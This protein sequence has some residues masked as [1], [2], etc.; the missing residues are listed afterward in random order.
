MYVP[1]WFIVALG[2]VLTFVFGEIEQKQRSAI[3]KLQDGINEIKNQL[4]EVQRKLG[5]LG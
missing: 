5:D 3:S 2:F 1:W 4:A